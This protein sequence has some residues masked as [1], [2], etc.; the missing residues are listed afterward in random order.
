MVSG[1]WILWSCEDGDKASSLGGRAKC[2]GGKLI[3][4]SGHSGQQN[5]LVTSTSS[6]SK[7]DTTGLLSQHSRTDKFRNKI[8]KKVARNLNLCEEDVPP[9]LPSGKTSFQD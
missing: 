4:F 8:S 9:L 1:H 2:L 7:A 6:L 5:L 3:S